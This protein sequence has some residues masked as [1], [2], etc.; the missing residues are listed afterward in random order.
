[1]YSK[2]DHIIDFTIRFDRHCE[3]RTFQ[4]F[5]QK[6]LLINATRIPSSQLENLDEEVEESPEEQQLWRMILG[7]VPST[8]KSYLHP[9]DEGSRAVIEEPYEMVWEYIPFTEQSYLHPLD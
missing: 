8:R 5:R 7:Y 2:I 6:S 4:H 1:L 9:L 3:R